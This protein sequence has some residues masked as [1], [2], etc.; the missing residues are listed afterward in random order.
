MNGFSEEY[1]RQVSCA[2]RP[3]RESA[4]QNVF[5]PGA[6]KGLD[7]PEPPDRRSRT[8]SRT[9]PRSA[10]ERPDVIIVMTTTALQSRS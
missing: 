6:Q 2:C 7:S 9:P 10:T 8:A 1:W 4:A 5:G 3:R